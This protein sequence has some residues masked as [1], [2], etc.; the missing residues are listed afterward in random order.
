M[1]CTWDQCTNSCT[2]CAAGLRL[3]A[4]HSSAANNTATNDHRRIRRCRR[5]RKNAEASATAL[6]RASALAVGVAGCPHFGQDKAS[7]GKLVPHL[8]H[9]D[10]VGTLAGAALFAAPAFWPHF[11]QNCEPSGRVVPHQLHNTLASLWS[12]FGVWAPRQDNW[13][14]ILG[15]V[16]V[17]L[18]FGLP[19]AFL[20]MARGRGAPLTFHAIFN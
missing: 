12:R 13:T 16:Y 19:L 5:A 3:V 11:K 1:V 6:A 20:E 7:R 8:A 15:T 2:S 9:V 18:L 17:W 4:S 14:N 10:R